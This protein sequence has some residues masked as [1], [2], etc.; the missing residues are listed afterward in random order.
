MRTLSGQTR[1]CAFQLAIGKRDAGADAQVHSLAV[2]ELGATPREH[3]GSR[4]GFDR[5][6][7]SRARRAA[8][9]GRGFFADAVSGRSRYIRE[10]RSNFGGMY[11]RFSAED[12]EE[13]ARETTLRVGEEFL[14]KEA[15]DPWVGPTEIVWSDISHVSK[16]ERAPLLDR[17]LRQPRDQSLRSSA[18]LRGEQF[19][20]VDDHGKHVFTRRVGKNS[21]G[22]LLH[23]ANG[24]AERIRLCF[25][26]Y[27]A[28]AFHETGEFRN[29]Q[30]KFLNSVGIGN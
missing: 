27:A 2:H 18:S 6:G 8:V 7:R 24:R 23:I 5:S 29:R 26:Q 4:H 11:H 28:G 15:I 3:S 30:E 9:R 14:P 22:V 25:L 17:K 10:S 1:G 20:E 16:V 13:T 19:V 12:L 21:L